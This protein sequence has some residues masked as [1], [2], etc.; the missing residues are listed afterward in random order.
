MRPFAA[1]L[2]ELATDGRVHA[3]IW[4]FGPMQQQQPIVFVIQVA[5]NRDFVGQGHSPDD[6]GAKQC[7]SKTK[8][9]ASDEGPLAKFTGHFCQREITQYLNRQSSGFQQPRF[10]C[11]DRVL[12]TR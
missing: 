4:R 6:S 2:I 11:V 8:A 12:H 3:C 5:K 9:A 7:G 1:D 10:A